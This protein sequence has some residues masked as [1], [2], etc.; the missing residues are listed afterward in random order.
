M[1][2][3]SAHVRC[4]ACA[5]PH[6]V[7]DP[8]CPAKMAIKNRL[9][10]TRFSA[11][12]NGVLC[13]PPDPMLPPNFAAD[14]F[15]IQD[16]KASL[17]R[18]PVPDSLPRRRPAFPNGNTRNLPQQLRDIPAST[19]SQLPPTLNAP[20]LDRHRSTIPALR[21]AP[22]GVPSGPRGEES[23][24]GLHRT[25]YPPARLRSSHNLSAS[26]TIQPAS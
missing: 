2:C 23:A 3:Q 8:R 16:I 24:N 11:D 19:P 4:P 21:E 12:G 7:Q 17:T 14:T 1:N 13:A 20:A 5:G 10:Q 18:P 6:S 9:R 15:A 25:D 22:L 26:G